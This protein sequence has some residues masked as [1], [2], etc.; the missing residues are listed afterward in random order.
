MVLI[1]KFAKDEIHRPPLVVLMLGASCLPAT[2]LILLPVA[3][4]VALPVIPSVLSVLL[5]AALSMLSPFALL[6]ILLVARPKLLPV[7]L[8]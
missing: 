5:P 6:V 1:Y 8:L 7:A 2:L 3:L 4:P